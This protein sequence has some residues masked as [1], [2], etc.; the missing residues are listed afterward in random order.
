MILIGGMEFLQSVRCPVYGHGKRNRLGTP[1]LV[2]AG[3]IKGVL[4]DLQVLSA[5][6]DQVRFCLPGALQRV[7]AHG[8]GIGYVDESAEVELVQLGVKLGVDIRVPRFVRFVAV[9]NISVEGSAFGI[10]NEIVLELL[11]S[12]AVP[13]VPSVMYRSSSSLDF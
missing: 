1:Q 7:P 6:S 5:S 4:D 10:D 9:M 11:V 12:W 13:A 8:N 3:F 2:P